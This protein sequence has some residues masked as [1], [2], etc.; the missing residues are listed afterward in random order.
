MIENN[1]YIVDE[2]E[3]FK[4]YARYQKA[5]E[6]RAEWENHWSECYDY[7]LPQ[8]SGLFTSISN[9]KKKNVDIFDSTAE[10]GVEQLAGSL[11]AQL[12]PP[13]SKWFGLGFGVDICDKD[14][15]DKQEKFK[16]LDDIQKVLQSHFQKIHLHCPQ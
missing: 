1:K 2:T 12:T 6:K 11:L 4:I 5:M 7:A 9:G 16:A 10:S 15:E 14:N 3:L 13:W 8:K